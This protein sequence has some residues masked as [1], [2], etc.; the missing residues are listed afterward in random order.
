MIRLRM[1]G[2]L[3]SGAASLHH[4][5]ELGGVRARVAFVCRKMF[6]SRRYVLQRAERN[7]VGKRTTTRAY[8]DYWWK[9][10]LR[11]SSPSVLAK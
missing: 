5:A 3:D 4:L 9:S 10:L 1:H 6:P 7:G 8:L 11:H 2:D